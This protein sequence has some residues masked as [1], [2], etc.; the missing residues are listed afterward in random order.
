MAQ[1]AG[2]GLAAAV[3][4]EAA[5]LAVGDVLLCASTEGQ[6]PVLAWI[7][8]TERWADHGVAGARGDLALI[9]LQIV[10]EEGGSMA[11]VGHAPLETSALKGCRTVEGSRMTP[12]LAAFEDGYA[13]WRDAIKDGAGAF[14]IGRADAYWA[15]TGIRDGAM[16]S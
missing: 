3:P 1:A 5:G 13:T 4:V 11:R 12:D 2:F 14:T 16:G 15:V 7:G 10:T 9:H 6:R 8:R